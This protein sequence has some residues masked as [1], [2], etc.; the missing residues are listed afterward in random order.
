MVLQINPIPWL[1]DVILGKPVH[2]CWSSGTGI[3]PFIEADRPLDRMIGEYIFKL[4][5]LGYYGPTKE[6]GTHQDQIMCIKPDDAIELY[7]KYWKGRDGT[8]CWQEVDIDLSFWKEGWGT[9]MLPKFSSSVYSSRTVVKRMVKAGMSFGS[10]TVPDYSSVTCGWTA[11]FRYG[12]YPP[13]PECL[14]VE[15]GNV[16]GH[17][18]ESE[19]VAICMAALKAYE[20]MN[21]NF[22][23]ET[24]QELAEELPEPYEDYPWE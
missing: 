1:R 11:V 21:D 9:L 8:A 24:L 2:K 13:G 16:W 19:H 22:R 4:P 5:G 18:D 17:Q 15:A 14:K 3:G 23:Y 20:G 6:H 12:I 10:W 7:K